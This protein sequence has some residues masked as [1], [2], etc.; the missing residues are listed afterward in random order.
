MATVRHG[1]PSQPQFGYLQVLELFT[2]QASAAGLSRLERLPPRLAPLPVPGPPG[3]EIGEIDGL[4]LDLIA[5]FAYGFC[6]GAG[7]R[8]TP[9]R[10]ADRALLAGDRAGEVTATPAQ[11]R[12]AFTAQTADVESSAIAAP[13]TTLL[14]RAV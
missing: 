9:G 2:A 11:H 10:V 7:A 3:T 5:Y 1:Q 14:M 13:V 8:L 6:A 12:D 4:C